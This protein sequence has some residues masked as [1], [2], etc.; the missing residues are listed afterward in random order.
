[1][2]DTSTAQIHPLRQLLTRLGELAAHPTAFA[3]VT[4]YAVLW[5]IF[6]RDSFDWHGAA[7]LATW[8]MT[9]FITRSE[10]RDT[11]AVQA[12][13]DELLRAHTRA[14]TE[15]T[16]LDDSEPEEIVRHR[17]EQGPET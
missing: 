3:I 7:T 11:Q 10:Y 8:L 6:E 2:N 9:F 17:K 15:L 16:K 12:K 4:A 13:L 5:L 1:M 14:R